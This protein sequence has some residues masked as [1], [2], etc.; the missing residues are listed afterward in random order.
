MPRRLTSRPKESAA[1]AEAE[2][3]Q[4]VQAAP[5][6]GG[7]QRLSR[8]STDPNVVAS[9]KATL[10]REAAEV[11]HLAKVPSE[12]LMPQLES[13][14]SF[15]RD[16]A[17]SGGAA[18]AAGSGSRTGEEAR[19]LAE[20]GISEPRSTVPAAIGVASGAELPRGG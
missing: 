11:H 14:L 10:R 18:S 13:V 9:A 8:L 12:E 3:E 19:A 2:E 16:G 1:Q 15:T 5:L 6:A 4:R 20:V 7:S 17:G